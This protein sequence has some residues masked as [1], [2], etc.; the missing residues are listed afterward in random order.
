MNKRL[1][2]LFL[3]ACLCAGLSGCGKTNT[4]GGSGIARQSSAVK[5]L[6]SDIAVGAKPAPVDSYE[7]LKNGI[8]K[9]A[10]ALYDA[11]AKRQQLLLFSLQYFQC[12]VHAG[13]GCRK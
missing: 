5:E 10:F 9:F 12:T 4:D 6:G 1:L 7:A 8:N 2:S 3:S 11:S 13:S